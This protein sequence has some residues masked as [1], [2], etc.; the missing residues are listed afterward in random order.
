MFVYLRGFRSGAR[1][2]SHLSQVLCAR[3]RAR[4]FVSGIDAMLLADPQTKE[5]YRI[6]KRI[7]SEVNCI[8]ELARRFDL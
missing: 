1:A 2:P 6:S 3:V 8:L 7:V 4:E 5:F